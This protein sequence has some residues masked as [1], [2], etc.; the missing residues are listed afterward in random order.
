MK[1]SGEPIRYSINLT[2]D[3]ES[4]N[5]KSNHKV[6]D[7]KTTSSKNLD[8]QKV[9][10]KIHQSIEDKKPIQNNKSSQKFFELAP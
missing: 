4:R 9:L 1:K 5:K 7:K 10:D 2:S 8:F 6:E 3:D